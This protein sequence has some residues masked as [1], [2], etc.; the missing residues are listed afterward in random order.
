MYLTICTWG[1]VVVAEMNPYLYTV[2]EDKI[3]FYNNF[4]V[5][6]EIY[7]DRS[8]VPTDPQMDINKVKGREWMVHVGIRP[9]ELLPHRL[10]VKVKRINYI[11]NH[12]GFRIKHFHFPLFYL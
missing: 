10:E 6:E 11:L 3:P 8:T 5:N 1:T 9:L 4:I 12:H 7:T 2:R